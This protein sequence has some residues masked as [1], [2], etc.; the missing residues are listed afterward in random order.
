MNYGSFIYDTIL[1]VTND[2][3]NERDD[4]E[5]PIVKKEYTCILINNINLVGTQINQ[6]IW[7]FYLM[8]IHSNFT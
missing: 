1:D 6:S 8:R 7:V 5:D 4:V 2:I 3:R